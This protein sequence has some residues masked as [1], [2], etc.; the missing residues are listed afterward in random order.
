M[1]VGLGMHGWTFEKTSVKWRGNN[2]SGYLHRGRVYRDMQ[3]QN[4][5]ALNLMDSTLF[6]G[7]KGEEN[8]MVM[9]KEYL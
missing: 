8:I 9:D 7:E 3:I 6:W 4:L 1:N 2:F 5:F